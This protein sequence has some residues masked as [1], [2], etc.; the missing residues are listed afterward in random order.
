MQAA[1]I[2]RFGGAEALELVQ[3]HPEPQVA[4][5]QVLVQ[6]HAAGLNPLDIKTRRGELR[7]IRG[8]KFPMVLGNDAS[9]V[10]VKCGR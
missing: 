3:D 7:W 6:V 9:G 1:V 2:N 5:N 10:V 8:A 4:D